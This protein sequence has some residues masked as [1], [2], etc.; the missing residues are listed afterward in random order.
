M[1][2]VKGVPITK[3]CDD[4]KLSLRQRL[5]L[6]R[7]V[8]E[9]VQHAH[10]KGIIHRDL[11]PTNVLVAEYDNRAV[12]KVIDFGV[13]KATAQKLTERT[14][15]TEFGQ[16]IGTVEYMSPEQAKF[17][18][19]DIDTRSDIYSLGVLLY[20]LLTGSTPFDRDRLRAA[21][22]DEVLRII[23]EEEP[24][25]PSTRLS[26]SGLPSW[27]SPQD[28]VLPSPTDPGSARQAGP[29][30]AT[31]AA[32]RQTEPSKLTKELSGEL[33][34]IVMKCLEKDRNRRYE[35]ASGLATE[36]QRYL[37]DEAVTASPP[38]AIY[39]LRKFARRNRTA[40]AIAALMI[41]FVIALGG[42]VGWAMR[43]RSAREAQIAR[44]RSVRRAALEQSVSSALDDAESL[45]RSDDLSEAMAAV[46]RAED[47]LGTG[48]ITP[49]L[50]TRID[51]WRADLETVVRLEDMSIPEAD[52]VQWD[53]SMSGHSEY[54]QEFRKLGIDVDKLTLEDAAKRI[55]SLRI[56]D[57][58]TQAL[59]NWTQYRMDLLY[60]DSNRKL[61]KPDGWAKRPLAVARL[62]D[63]DEYHG[64][65][66]RAIV[67]YD[68]SALVTLLDLPAAQ[69]LPASTLRLAARDLYYDKQPD[70]RTLAIQVLQRAQ[71][72]RPD[73]FSINR[74]FANYLSQIRPPQY[75]DAIRYWSAAMARRPQS[76]RV[77]LGLATALSHSGRLDES[78]ANFRAAI[79][80]QPDYV[81]AYNNLGTALKKQGKHDEALAVCQKAI[82]LSPELAS[83]YNT[84]GTVLHEQGKLDEAIAAYR[85][86][87]ELQ[88]DMPQPYNNL[89]N[90]LKQQGKLDEAVTALRKAVELNPPEIALAYSN[91]GNVLA[92]RRDFDEAIDA[93]RKAIELE[94]DNGRYY[95]NLARARENQ[96]Q[97]DEAV[98]GYRK[99]IEVDPSLDWPYQ[100]LGVL[101]SNQGKLDEALA[102]FRK[103]I[104]VN[105]KY[106]GAYY[107]LADVL[108][109]LGKLEEA[110]AAYQRTI[111]LNPKYA[112]AY[113]NLGDTLRQ[114]RRFD[115]AI[116]ACR[117]AVELEPNG[118]VPAAAYFNLGLTFSEQAKSDEAIDAYR[119]S[120]DNNPA[121]VNAYVNLGVLL[122]Q[123]GNHGE[124]VDAFRKAI[125]LGPADADA[126]SN[127]S[128]AL[129]SQGKFDEAI[130]ACRR[131][132]ELQP[133]HADAHHN[134]GNGLREQGNLDDAAAA[135]RKEI[136]LLPEDAEAHAALGRVLHIQWK[137]SEADTAWRKALSL[138][139][140]ANWFN[141]WAWALATS[142]NPRHRDAPRAVELAAKAVELTPTNGGYWNTLGIAH[143]RAGQWQPAIDAM[144]KSI[145][146]QDD[147]AFDAFFLAM[148][149]WQ[150]GQKDE[151]RK[152]YDKAIEW[153][154]KNDPDNVELQRFRAEA[155]E[156]LGL[157]EPQRSTNG[158]PQTKDNGQRTTDD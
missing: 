90:V 2:L 18:Q 127:L 74:E 58:L 22:F 108:H 37:N 49:A 64:R 14:M 140:D 157:T 40:I 69:H 79:K 82:E 23:R 134:L 145:E 120:I 3:Y 28:A 156:L 115:E 84:L 35:T 114:L 152:W 67:N 6:F 16:V 19:L 8:C 45:F 21:A 103:A 130:A 146:L 113:S 149:H 44:E 135:F 9:A 36:L 141:E 125:E 65:V 83:P 31:I 56:R 20:E 98:A 101:L 46:T 59:D 137:R 25:K 27:T 47:L 75:A 147:N 122:E 132:I 76:S 62:A 86:A 119:K 89:G 70:H 78:V 97:L 57:Q 71:M 61:D 124:A 107:N 91:L 155:A 72:A 150:V 66:R 126:Y 33:D 52:G 138:P 153:M 96:G 30:L 68:M 80:L 109:N 129:S 106:V 54:D 94:P 42:A 143:Y 139:N 34:W 110:V 116:A 29:T 112:A 38:S 99:A 154:D 73:D 104:E 26:R 123:V 148:A 63:P 133:D 13:A 121:Y 41:S 1:D 158:S 77:R 55:R 32:N 39:R 50:E 12:P 51:Q 17:N 4:H 131:A 118:A 136:E 24:P 81:A 117:K 93:F 60:A 128:V 43:D 5:E 144:T 15:F 100:N 88:P 7:P 151:A 92:E 102:A 11:K 111:E 53:A 10:Q 87:I 48:E 142:P 85:K 105:P 95:F